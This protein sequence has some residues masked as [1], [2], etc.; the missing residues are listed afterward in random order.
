LRLLVTGG[1][2]FIGSN[3]VRRLLDGSLEGATSVIVLDNLTYAG[4]LKNLEEVKT[5]SR[6]SFVKGDICDAELVSNLYRDIDAVVHFAA[7][8]HV[9]RSIASTEEFVRTNVLGTNTLLDALRKKKSIRFVSVST[10]EVYGSINAGSW[11]ETYPLSPN[12]PYS[13]SKAASD[14]LALAHTNTFGLNLSITRCGNNYGPFQYP[15][16][17]IPLFVT[18]L[19]RGKKVPVYG[20]GMNSREWVHVDDHCHGIHQV[21]LKGRAGE[22][23]NLGSQN[24][25]TN[26]EITKLIIQLMGKTMDQIEFVPDR[27]NHDFRYALNFQKA[28]SELGYIEKVPFNDGIKSTIDWYTTNSSWWEPLLNEK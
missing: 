5:D 22:V 13:A 10:D 9:D 23:Y 18:N 19:L 21:L 15:E 17:L 25:M 2:G 14:M 8:S 6:F 1:A 26:I 7:E 27:A 3:Y 4:N 16:K 28:K 24:D 11:D 20:D 12:S